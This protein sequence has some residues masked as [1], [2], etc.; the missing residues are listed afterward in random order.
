VR[1]PKLGQWIVAAGV[2]A[3]SAV[4]ATVAISGLGGATA[5][6]PEAT[7][8][9]AALTVDLASLPYTNGLAV[10]QEAV[11]A[12][13]VKA[14]QERVAAEAAAEAARVAAE[15]AAAEAE[16]VAAEQAAA[17]A[18]YD[19]PAAAPVS[20]PT[21]CPPGSL[22]NSGDGENHTSCFP[23]ECF[24]VTLP[25]PSYPQCVTAFKP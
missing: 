10:E 11:A 24:H 17:E 5:A 22:P 23:E 9:P 14:E 12:A 19:A 6:Q 4:I 1:K 13:A 18:E 20:G 3:V 15:Q 21:K 25:D 2:V 16:R 7:A 8:R